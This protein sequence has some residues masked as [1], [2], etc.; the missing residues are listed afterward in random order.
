MTTLIIWSIAAIIY[1]VFWL[2]YVGLRTKVTP[3]EADQ[4]MATL[5]ENGVEDAQAKSLRDFF[6]SDNGKDFVMVNLLDLKAP[7]AESG[8]KLAA[9]SKVFTGELLR[10]GGHP[11]ASAGT[12]VGTIENIACEDFD[13]WDLAVMMRYRSRRDLMEMMIFTAGTEHRT[14]K[15]EALEKTIAFPSTGWSI[16]GGPRVLVPVAVALVAA[17]AQIILG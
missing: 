5:I 10:K 7:K 4:A 13:N 14:W 6:A 12:R 11:V 15:L 17:L 9:Y 8:K 3:A 16:V 1:G 2:W